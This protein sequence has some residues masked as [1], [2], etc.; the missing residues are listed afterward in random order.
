[1]GIRRQYGKHSS[2]SSSRRGSTVD[3]PPTMSISTSK[4]SWCG[5]SRRCVGISII[6]HTKPNHPLL[7]LHLPKKILLIL[8][9][10]LL[11]LLRVQLTLPPIIRGPPPPFMS[12]VESLK[13]TPTVLQF[14]RLLLLLLLLLDHDHKSP[15]VTK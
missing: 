7:L 10:L 6:D 5:M 15:S 3:P 14:E 11:L 12:F 9:L 13:D 8:L 1:M 2:S 4:N